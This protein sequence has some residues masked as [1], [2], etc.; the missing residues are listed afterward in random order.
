[1]G[2]ICSSSPGVR[3]DG[4]EFHLSEGQIKE[5]IAAPGDDNVDQILATLMI[6]LILNTGIAKR[7]LFNLKWSDLSY[8]DHNLKELKISQYLLTPGRSVPYR[9]KPEI[10]KILSKH[11]EYLKECP[12][13]IFPW[14]MRF[15]NHVLKQYPIV[16]DG[17]IQTVTYEVLRRTYA[18]LLYADGEDVKAIQQKLGFRNIKK[19]LGFIGP[20]EIYREERKQFFVK[21]EL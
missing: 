8:D 12:K 7:E 13:K 17:S 3:G 18:R 19:V 4:G 6:A 14:R 11:V 5:L 10:Q 15:T 2:K 9:N 21:S 1:L 20:L 16:V